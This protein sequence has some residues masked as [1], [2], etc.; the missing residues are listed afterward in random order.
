MISRKRGVVSSPRW[1]NLKAFLMK[2]AVHYGIKYKTLEEGKNFIRQ[3]IYFEI[4]GE[5][6]YLE[7]FCQEIKDLTNE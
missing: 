6:E 4:E 1:I 5:D 2:R 3:T 7:K